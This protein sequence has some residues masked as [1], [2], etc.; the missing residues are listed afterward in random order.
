VK[1]CLVVANFWPGWGGA[2]R[3][4]QLLARTLTR[5]EHEVVV[6]TRGHQGLPAEDH[7]DGVTVRRTTAF[8]SRTLQSVVWTLSATTWLRRHAR[9]F[10]IVQCYQL[11][12]PSHIGL[13][14]CPRSGRSATVLRPACGGPYGD[15]AEVRRLPL[16]EMRKRLLRRADVYVTLTKEIEAELIEFGLGGVPF[17]RIPNGVDAAVFSPAPSEERAT[18][19][20]TSGLPTDKILCAFVGRLTRQKNPEVLLEAWSRCETSRMHLVFVG[21]G[22]LRADLERQNSRL[23]SMRN[24]T[25]TGA[26]PDV[27]AFVRAMD[28]MVLPSE[29]EGISNAML[30]AMAC[31]LSVVAT[32]VGGVREVL[33]NDG[34]AGVVVPAGSSAALAEAITTLAAS[35]ALRREIG[36]AART[37]IE[38]RYDMRQV[39][40]QYLSLYEELAG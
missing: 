37:L 13:L 30:E 21:D 33:G 29:A 23:P 36:A 40:A 38:D 22:P 34:T 19:R 28:I 4:C 18:L 15:I 31:G 12:S 9:Q 11:L 16:T 24:V 7:F 1:I 26:V 14:G 20:A 39:M 25:F 3:Q 35:P 32:D 27:P 10:P 6:L 5:H 17:R 8:G 2:E